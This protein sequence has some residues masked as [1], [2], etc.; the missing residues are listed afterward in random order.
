[1][2]QN[3]THFKRFVC[4]GWICGYVVDQ[5]FSYRRGL[6][7][8]RDEGCLWN[9]YTLYTRKRARAHTHTHTH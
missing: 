4:Y 8:K 1:M 5:I 3:V 2:V 6:S 7:P 9:S